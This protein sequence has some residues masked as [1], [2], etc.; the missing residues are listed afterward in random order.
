MG[1][2]CIAIR[3]TNFEREGNYF[4]KLELALGN[5]NNNGGNNNIKDPVDKLPKHRTEVSQE[6]ANPTFDQKRFEFPVPTPLDSSWALFITACRIE[7]LPDGGAAVSVVGSARTPLYELLSPLLTRKTKEMV[8]DLDLGAGLLAAAGVTPTL[9]PLLY[10]RLTIAVSLTQKPGLVAEKG[11]R[12][13][14]EATSDVHRFEAPELPVAKREGSGGYGTLLLARSLLDLTRQSIDLDDNASVFSQAAEPVLDR[15]E[16]VLDSPTRND[17]PPENDSGSEETMKI[18]ATLQRPA[19]PAKSLFIT[20]QNPAYPGQK[21]VVM[22]HD[23]WN[24]PWMQNATTGQPSL[25]TAFVTV[26]T[27]KEAAQNKRAKAA[28]HVNMPSREASFGEILVL[29]LPEPYA[30]S[31]VPS[32]FLTVAD[33]ITRRFMA[34]YV[35]P[36]SCSQFP[37]HRQLSLLLRSVSPSRDIPSPSLRVSI[38]SIDTFVSSPYMLQR[39]Y[40]DKMVFLELVLKGIMKN[41]LPFAQRCIAVVKVIASGSEY[42]A[43]MKK[44]QRRF[45]EGYPPTFPPLLPAVQLD[46][47][48]NGKLINESDLAK[49]IYIPDLVYNKGR[50]KPP[51]MVAGR[52]G[53]DSSGIQ[54]YY[55]MTVASAFDVKP[56]WNQYFLFVLNMLEFSPET[57]L[58]IEFYRDPAVV[59]QHYHPP[60]EGET[61]GDD[62]EVDEEETGRPLNDLFGYAIVPLGD[63]TTLAITESGKIKSFDDIRVHFVG[64]YGKLP[65]TS[66]VFC[67]LD[68]KVPDNW[69]TSQD[70]APEKS[71]SQKSKRNFRDRKGADA[72]PDMDFDELISM[73]KKDREEENKSG[74]EITNADPTKMIFTFHDIQQRQRLIDRLLHELELRTE[75]VRKVGADLFEL[76][77]VNTNLEQKI[78]QLQRKIAD[79][80]VTTMRLLNTVDIDVVPPDELKKPEKLQKE[81]NNNRELTERL[82]A[83]QNN[84]IERNDL[85]KKYLE[86]RQAHTAQAT[87]IQ[88]LQENL[89]QAAKYKSAITKQEQVIRK[90][91]ILLKE[92]LSP[93]NKER[94]DE[95]FASARLDPE[96]FDGGVYKLLTDENRTLKEK[97]LQLERSCVQTAADG[98]KTVNY[99]E[100]DELR[101]ELGSQK[102][103]VIELEQQLSES[104]VGHNAGEYLKTYMRAE[105][106]EARAQVLENEP[107]IPNTGYHLLHSVRQPLET[108][109]Q[110]IQ[111]LQLHVGL[112][113]V[114]FR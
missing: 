77:E 112:H 72:L 94:L 63:F 102:R 3:S 48:P 42:A 38:T 62:R 107:L 44:F 65:G 49:E 90:L 110:N 91:E 19:T 59:V 53:D 109:P 24:L 11:G 64:R 7:R 82:E 69:P 67:A 74:V 12:N 84:A 52:H 23:L 58:L 40:D 2:F 41:P 87:Y 26:K 99:E 54:T 93:N 108:H 45:E 111:I 46:F 1:G 37:S 4:L 96:S 95:F 18:K 13:R 97:L 50:K 25:P 113:P 106:A 17:P 27:A 61:D 57:S 55:Q 9:T 6:T 51:A 89:Q 31:N 36:I 47:D 10:A 100:M 29:D 14:K 88:K 56:M 85:E 103:R 35:I 66:R 34:R 79:N 28:T 15:L 80:E 75:A 22:V 78:H 81:M 30:Q 21:I 98:L 43:R 32:I 105:K 83:L 39:E 73:V 16:E 92:S 70:D 5:S 60:K 104:L 8:K 71:K 20:T 33:N 68:I 76:R 114:L 101:K 86:L